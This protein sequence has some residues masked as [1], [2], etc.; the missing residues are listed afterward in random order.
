VGPGPVQPDLV[1]GL[2]VARADRDHLLG[3]AAAQE[4]EDHGGQVGREVRQDRLD[5][6]LRDWLDRG[7]LAGLE[8]ALA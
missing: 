8:A 5:R 3:A 4:L 1:A 6:R 2:D 7:C